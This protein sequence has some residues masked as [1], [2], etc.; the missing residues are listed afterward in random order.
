MTW[1]VNSAPAEDA[2]G[3]WEVDGAVLV[4]MNLTAGEHNGS[5]L[6][7]GGAVEY[8]AV[9]SVPVISAGPQSATVNES[10]DIVLHCSVEGGPPL[11][12]VWIKDDSLVPTDQSRVVQLANGSLL[13]TS[14]SRQD[15]G[16]YSCRITWPGDSSTSPPANI[17][18][19]CE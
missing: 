11:S 18:V 13:V 3:G 19:Q 6:S 5:V 17:T 10:Q 2:P 4:Q 15:A 14:A 16:E 1:L 9:R 12:T 7:C 8:L